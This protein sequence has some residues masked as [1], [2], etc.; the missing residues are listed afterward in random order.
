[1][2]S[3]RIGMRGAAMAAG[4]AAAIP[5]HGLGRIMGRRDMVPPLFLQMIGRAAGLRIRIE[6]TAAPGALF[7]ANHIS[8][9]DIPALATTSRSVFVAHSGLAENPALKWLCA[10]NKTVFIARDRRAS[11]ASQVDLVRAALGRRPVTIFP[12][13]TTGDGRSMLPF[14]SSLLAA[15]EPL[16]HEVPVQPVALDYHNAPEIAWHGPQGGL[17]NARQVLSRTGRIELVIRFLDP[18]SGRQLHNRKTMAAAAHQAVEQALAAG[19][20]ARL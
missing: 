15:V 14:H 18:L 17:E 11:V 19:N 4:F 20:R 10:Q 6:G 2:S 7:L 3:L 1:M 12:E 5:A 13:A 16:A 9:L 8:W